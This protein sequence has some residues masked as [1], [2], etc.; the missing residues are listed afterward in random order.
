M[1]IALFSKNETE[2]L[3]SKLNRVTLDDLWHR[4]EMLGDVQV[5]RPVFEKSYRVQ[6]K[7]KRPGTES[8]VWATGNARN[9]MDAMCGAIQ[10]AELLSQ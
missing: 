2:N 6:I 7:F 5:D 10:E 3:A 8:T 9:I 1:N 4:A